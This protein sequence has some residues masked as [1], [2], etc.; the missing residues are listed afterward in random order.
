MVSGFVESEIFNYVQCRKLKMANL[1]FIFSMLIK[2][3]W[4]Y[5]YMNF[6]VKWY[7]DSFKCFLLKIDRE[8]GVKY[9]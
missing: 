1:T 5:M 4:K 8:W 7:R 9:I 6:Y 3:I 2:Y